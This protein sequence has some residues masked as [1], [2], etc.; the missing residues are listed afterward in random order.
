MNDLGRAP[1]ARGMSVRDDWRASLPDEKYR[2]FRSYEQQLETSYNMLSVSLDEALAL[3]QSGRSLKA[4]QAVCVTPEL[5]ERFASPLVA[6]LWSL[7][8]HAKHYGTV[9]NA[10]PLDPDNF[11]GARGQRVALLSALLCK[12]LFSQRQQFLHKIS[13]LSE[14]VDDLNQDFRSAATEIAASSAFAPDDL[15]AAVD[16]THY[17]LN[18]CFREAVVLLKS[19]LISLP[20]SELGTFQA[21]V[22]IQMGV[23]QPSKPRKS[24]FTQRLFRHRRVAA[25][26]GE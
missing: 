5:C 8:E 21:T 26:S 3:H 11:L 14:M 4:S 24:S 19:F 20:E 1:S 16:A 22:R 18:T 13:T 2:V 9:P 17:D 7:S 12:V 25:I 23:A 10:A 6:L 15:W